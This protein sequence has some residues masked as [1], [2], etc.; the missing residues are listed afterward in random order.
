[1]SYYW[2]ACDLVPGM[3]IAEAS[4]RTGR[5]KDAVLSAYRRHGVPFTSKRR[6]YPPIRRERA[7]RLRSAGYTWSQV[8]AAV[9]VSERTAK[10]WAS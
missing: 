2:R 7:L 4:R 6:G 3:T 1:M 10:G 5:S 8:A 9:G